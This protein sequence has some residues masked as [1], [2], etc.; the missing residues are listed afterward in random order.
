M[1]NG[2]LNIDGLDAREME[3]DMTG[4]EIRPDDE[5]LPIDVY[6]EKYDRSR[7]SYYRDKAA[8]RF[9]VV[10]IGGSPR[11]VDRSV[12]ERLKAA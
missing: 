7:A 5:L 12:R 8:G 4:F 3:V 6:C 9:H 1:T 11:I 2:L 10:M